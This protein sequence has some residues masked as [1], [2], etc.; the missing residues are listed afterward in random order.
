MLLETQ[1]I[2]VFIMTVFSDKDVNKF[3]A[4]SHLEPEELRD[5]VAARFKDMGMST[6]QPTLEAWGRGQIKHLLTKDPKIRQR[7]A[8]E[9]NIIIQRRIKTHGS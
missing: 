1:P 8:E 4:G 6:I 3:V 9:Q 5:L 7:I 2:E